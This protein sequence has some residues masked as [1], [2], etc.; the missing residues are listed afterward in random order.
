LVGGLI[1]EIGLSGG[2]PTTDVSDCFWDTQT[3]GQSTS[4]AGTGKTTAEMKTLSTFTDA[5]WDFTDIWEM[6]TSDYPRL[7][8]ESEL[9]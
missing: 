3:S 8:W 7:Q 9:D 1:G 6:P 4:A 2:L 5:G